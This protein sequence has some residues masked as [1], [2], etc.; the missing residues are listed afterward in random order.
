MIMCAMV[1]SSF[2]TVWLGLLYV[3]GMRALFT[4]DIFLY[5]TAVLVIWEP[6]AAASP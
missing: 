4:M 2:P 1:F 6:V 5:T 3:L